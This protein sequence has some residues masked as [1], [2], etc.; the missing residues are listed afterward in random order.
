MFVN[1]ESL[2]YNSMADSLKTE[3]T[4][5]NRNLGLEYNLASADNQYNGKVFMLKSFGPDSSYNGFAQGAHLAYN[6]RKWNWRVQQEYISEN[7]TSE[8]GFVPRNNYIKLEGS[9]GYQ[10][11]PA[12]EKVV[13]HGP[14]YTGFII[15][16]QT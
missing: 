10:F 13:S 15:S 4:K 5:F 6:S 2:D 16:T 9:V 14:Q 12:S 8:V 1:K 7:F 11:L 3:Y